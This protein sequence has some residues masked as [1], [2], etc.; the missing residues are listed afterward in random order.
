MEVECATM[1][2]DSAIKALID[3]AMYKRYHYFKR[4]KEL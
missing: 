3:E 2:G 4:K 1:I